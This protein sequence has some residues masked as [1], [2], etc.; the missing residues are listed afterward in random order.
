MSFLKLKKL[1][2]EKYGAEIPAYLTYHGTHHIIDVLNSCNQYIKRYKLDQQDSRLLRTAA[3]FH[4]VGILWSYDGHEAMGISYLK[5]ILP[6]WKYSPEEIEV[7]CL[8]ISATKIPQSPKTLLDQILCDAD[9]DY[10]GTNNFYKI[11]TTL[12]HELK[13]LG[14]I[15]NEK[16]WDQLQIVFLNNHHYHTSF[17]KKH[18]APK[19]EKFKQELID[20]YK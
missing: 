20:K 2:L 14:I 3:I 4:D 18:R 16:E 11:G 6:N 5:N 10:L 19:K 12:F 9:L 1:V 13:A 15:S 7:I 17:A 8:M